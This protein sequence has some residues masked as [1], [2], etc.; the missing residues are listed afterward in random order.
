MIYKRRRTSTKLQIADAT[1][2][3]L[4]NVGYEKLTITGIAKRADIGRGTFYR[5]FKSIESAI[6]FIFEAHSQRLDEAMY[7]LMLQYESPEREQQVW[8]ATF[9]YLEDLKPLFQRVEGKG[10]EII[11]QQ[12]ENHIMQR[13]R[14]SLESGLVMYSNWMQLPVDVMAHFTGGAVLSVVR[15]WFSG[16]LDYDSETMGDMVYQMLYHQAP[17]NF[18]NKS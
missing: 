10:S 11:W 16:E 13:F 12:F 17:N 6:L 9:H 18:V 4:L 5:Y 2:A 15:H 7:E 14:A 1:I 8:R 3:E